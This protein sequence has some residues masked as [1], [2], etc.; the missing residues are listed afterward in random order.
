MKIDY[1]KG[2]KGNRKGKQNTTSVGL[3]SP[4]P[5][6][7]PRSSCHLLAHGTCCCPNPP[8][9]KHGHQMSQLPSRHQHL[10]GSRHRPAIP[11]SVL[12]RHRPDLAATAWPC[13]C[14]RRLTLAAAGCRSCD[15]IAFP[16]NRCRLTLQQPLPPPWGHPDAVAAAFS[17]QRCGRWLTQLPR[18]APCWRR[19]FT[20]LFKAAWMPR[21]PAL[22]RRHLGEALGTP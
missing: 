17:S 8:G 16:W 2:W 11:C 22:L 15:P 18:R 9:E 4:G 20:R 10:L 3:H 13:N 1:N 21:R 19:R 5:S 14:S 6:G 12:R 7:P